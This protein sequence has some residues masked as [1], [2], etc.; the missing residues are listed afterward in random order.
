[1]LY[2][3]R[4]VKQFDY[5]ILYKQ[6]VPAYNYLAVLHTQIIPELEINIINCINKTGRSSRFEC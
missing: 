6:E 5:I 2:Q 4:K 3:Q 1:M